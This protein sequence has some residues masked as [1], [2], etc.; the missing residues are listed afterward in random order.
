MQG[1][2]ATFWLNWVHTDNWQQREKARGEPALKGHK[3]ANVPLKGIAGDRRAK[4]K[5]LTFSEAGRGCA[6]QERACCYGLQ[7]GRLSENLI[8]QD[9]KLSVMLGQWHHLCITGENSVIE[10]TQLV[11]RLIEL[12]VSHLW[13]VLGYNNFRQLNQVFVFDLIPVE[14]CILITG[15]AGLVSNCGW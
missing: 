4:G 11:Q 13:S 12:T 7:R 2:Y 10:E 5:G 6:D 8:T 9:L 14:L 3:L 1:I 15:S